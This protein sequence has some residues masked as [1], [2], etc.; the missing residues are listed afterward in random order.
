MCTFYCSILSLRLGHDAISLRDF[1]LLDFEHIVSHFSFVSDFMT[2]WARNLY[3]CEIQKITQQYSKR[4]NNE[5]CFISGQYEIKLLHVYC[6]KLKFTAFPRSSNFS[7][8]TL[9]MTIIV[10]SLPVL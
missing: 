6:C 4:E 7:Y 2:N 9:K 5:S 1:I 3:H 8:S 10:P